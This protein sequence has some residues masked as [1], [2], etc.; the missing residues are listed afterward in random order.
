MSFKF[1]INENIK[2]TRNKEFLEKAEESKSI[3]NYEKYKPV[4]CIEVN[5][6]TEIKN[7]QI[8]D[9]HSKQFGRDDS[10]ILDFGEHHVGKFSIDINRVGSMMDAPLTIKFQFAEIS[11]ELL[12]NPDEYDGWLSRSWIP[13]E[14]LHIDELPCKLHL[15]RRYSF[16]Y[17]K[18]TVIDTSPKWKI[19]LN[20]PIVEAQSAILNRELS[21][22]EL[23]GS[24]QS[25]Q[26][27]EKVSLKTLAE[28]MQDVFEDGPK[29]DQRLWLGDLHLQAL[30]NYSTFKKNSLVK[31]CLYLFAGMTTEDGKVSANIFTSKDEVPDDTFLL[32]YSLFFVST[33]KDYL[34]NTQDQETVRELYPTAK[35]QIDL[36]LA[37]VNGDGKLIIPNEWPSF[38]DWGDG[39]DKI[40]A[41][42][43]VLIYVLKDFLE[44]SKGLIIEV[45]DEY[46]KKLQL[47]SDYSR[48]KL[49]DSSRQLFISGENA[50]LN[51]YS[52]VWMILAGVFPENI[53]KSIMLAT[54]KRFFPIKNIETPYM[55]HYVVTALLKVNMRTEAIDLINNYWGSMISNGADTFWEAYKPDEPNFSPYGSPLVNSYCHAW[56]CTP[57]Y[58]INEYNL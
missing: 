35:K 57:V 34:E 43:G 1:Q 17:V 13:I 28:C 37:C 25:L 7:T 26:N 50:E 51:I 45:D 33:L 32:D 5:S 9:L 40:T 44:L 23:S 16:R 18:I 12:S 3:L 30:V 21:N 39:F 6:S 48:K 29:R 47:L 2:F 55:Y 15:P 49:Y 58:L 22:I 53:E 38:I 54:Y 4:R 19:E 20:N 56:S 27:I 10:I 42:Q 24:T 14:T 8:K 52:Q 36:A 46:N 41:T 11:N 31:R